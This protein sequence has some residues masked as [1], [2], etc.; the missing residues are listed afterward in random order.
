MPDGRDAGSSVSQLRPELR[1][2][3]VP[4]LRH[5]LHVRGSGVRL[6]K[7]LRRDSAVSALEDLAGRASGGRRLRGNCR[8]TDLPT[9]R[10]PPCRA[11]L[12]KST[13]KSRGEDSKVG[14]RKPKFGT[15]PSE[16]KSSCAAS[17]FSTFCCWRSVGWRRGVRG[18]QGEIRLLTPPCRTSAPAAAPP[19]RAVARA[20]GA[21]RPQVE[22]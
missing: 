10:P 18:S 19:V 17:F 5:Q 7:D 3:H 13:T 8:G 15:S 22:R 1:E 6:R 11:L 12:Q 2:W 9:F 16:R 21:A 14:S 20:R 4:G